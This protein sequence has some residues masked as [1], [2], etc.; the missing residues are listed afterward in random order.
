MKKSGLIVVCMILFSFFSCTTKQ[1]KEKTNQIPFLFPDYTFVTIP[2]NIAPLNFE[3]KGASFVKAD[4]EMEG[5]LLKTITGNHTIAISDKIWHEWLSAYK[6]KSLKITISIWNDSHPDGLSYR[7]FTIH[8]SPDPIDGWIAYRLIEPGYEL[9]HQMGIYQRSLTSF[10]EDPVV[11]NMQNHTGCVNCH[12]FLNYSPEQFMFHARGAGGGTVIYSHG[13]LKK[14]DMS[15]LN[16]KMKGVYPMWHRSGN[17]IVFSSNKTNQSFFHAGKA[18]IEVYDQASDLF[19]YDVRNNREIADPRFIDKSY[20]ETFPAFSPDGKYLYFCRAKA[21]DM[22]K[23]YQKLKYALCRVSFNEKE[24]TFGNKIDTLYNPSVETG[25]VSFPRI[26][27][28]GQY[29]LYTE[30]ANG[31]FPIWHR[32][33]D[34]KMIRLNDGKKI[35][36]S[37]LNSK[38]TESYHSWSSNGRWVIFSSRRIDGRYT[39][40][41]IAHIDKNGIVDKPFLLPQKDPESNTLRLKSYNIPEFISGKVDLSKQ[42]V[43]DLL[44]K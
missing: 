39:R 4:F 37:A 9:W 6:G 27:P 34:L 14:I 36:V 22:P 16:L 43:A 20:F 42:Q 29:L 21:V 10:E 8:I 31:T 33:A 3:I 26:S 19:I 28:D 40:L 32:E 35:D 15:G 30:A 17:Y 1:A 13:K 44:N 11:T 23:E 12:S 38:E 5:K 7:P 2:N 25:S 41:F 24:G 18:P